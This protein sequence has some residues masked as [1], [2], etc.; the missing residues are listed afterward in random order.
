MRPR[1]YFAFRIVARTDYGQRQIAASSD[2]TTAMAAYRT[3]RECWPS[4]GITLRHA[5]RVIEHSGLT[6]IASR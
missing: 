2:L 5:N 4:A 6:R 1:T 3:A